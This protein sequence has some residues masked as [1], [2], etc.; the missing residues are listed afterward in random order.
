MKQTVRAALLASAF[1]GAS[2]AAAAAD[3]S[4]GYLGV[5]VGYRNH[6]NFDCLSG[7]PCDRNAGA[8]TRVYGGFV[9]GENEAFGLPHT[10]AVE[11]AAFTGGAVKGAFK[12]GSG[13]L[14][15]G[16][17]KLSG[18][19]AVLASATKLSEDWAWTTRLGLVAEHGKVDYTAG[20][21]DST[22]TLAVTAGTG[23]SYAIDKHWALNADWNYLP[24]RM[25]K[26]AKS[27][28][29]VFSVGAAYHF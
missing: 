13:A 12:D 10:R 24:A 4:P 28:L 8:S 25:G 2:G 1:L 17:G 7:S 14:S 23:L 9:L 21:S 27:N 11:V 16:K 20:G 26:A 5:D 3:L 22:N 6:Y 29:N 19:S 18:V 15:P